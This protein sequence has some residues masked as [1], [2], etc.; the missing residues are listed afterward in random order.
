VPHSFCR[1]SD[2]NHSYL[3]DR[4]PLEA[5]ARSAL[6]R[7]LAD[8]LFRDYAPSTANL[9]ASALFR[10]LKL[11][12]GETDV[13][14]PWRALYDLFASVSFL[15]T[16][17]NDIVG[18]DTD[19]LAATLRR[20]IPR[21]RRYFA[22]GCVPEMLE[23][24]SAGLVY[25]NHNEAERCL[26][27]LSLFLPHHKEQFRAWL[28]PLLPVWS[29]IVDH[30]TWDNKFLTLIARA[31]RASCKTDYTWDALVE[32]MFSRVLVRLDI[33]LG[34]SSKLVEG[35]AQRQEA[36]AYGEIGEKGGVATSF[37]KWA[38][39]ALTPR[40][41]DPVFAAIER[42]LRT[43]ETYYHPSNTGKW[44][45]SLGAILSVMASTL[46]TRHRK[47]L[48][49]NSS[50]HASK[51]LR[52]EDR[53]RVV[54]VLLRVANYAL[55]SKDDDMSLQAR[56]AIRSLGYLSPQTVFDPLMERLYF[57]L[58]TVT[59]TH[60]TSLA[61]STL[62]V[63]AHPLFSRTI[64]PAGARHLVPFL[65]LALPGIDSND[66]AKTAE[67]FKFFTSALQWVPLIDE[68]DSDYETTN[69]NDAAAKMATSNFGDWCVQLWNQLTVY[70]SNLQ[71]QEKLSY[72]AIWEHE[73][74]LGPFLRVFF[75]QMSPAFRLSFVRNQIAEYVTR[76]RHNNAEN[77]VLL[78]ITWA[79][80]SDPATVL[81]E[82]IPR[83]LPLVWKKDKFFDSGV[84]SVS[85]ALKLLSGCARRAGEALVPFVDQLTSTALAAIQYNR[86]PVDNNQVRKLGHELLG[87]ML[88]GLVSY[89]VQDTFYPKDKTNHFLLWG[90]LV[91]QADL[92]QSHWVEPTAAAKDAAQRSIQRVLAFAEEQIRDP[93][94]ADAQVHQACLALVAVLRAGNAF[95]FA[96]EEVDLKVERE[97]ADR[98][99]GRASYL[100]VPRHLGTEVPQLAFVRPALRDLIFRLHDALKTKRA[101]SSDPF[102]DL[103]SVMDSYQMGDNNDAAGMVQLQARRQW[104]A[105]LLNPLD[106]KRQSRFLKLWKS[107]AFYLNLLPLRGL[108]APDTAQGR[109]M[110]GQL[111]DL[112]VSSYA[113]VRVAAQETLLLASMT[114][115]GPTR[116]VIIPRMVD[117]LSQTESEDVA[118]G[119][120]HFF[121]D[122]IT[123]EKARM[124]RKR[125]LLL[126]LCKCSRFDNAKIQVL[127]SS[128]FSQFR[129]I[130]SGPER[131]LTSVKNEFTER[132]NRQILERNAAIVED[133]LTLAATGPHWRYELMICVA[134]IATM[135]RDSPSP[136]A[137]R[138]L[139]DRLV[140][141]VQQI[142]KVAITGVTLILK[143][144]GPT[145]PRV[146]EWQDGMRE[147]EMYD[148][149]WEGF[150]SHRFWHKH[151]TAAFPTGGTPDIVAI[152]HEAFARPGFAEKICT[153]LAIDY[154]SPAN[155]GGGFSGAHRGMSQM[156]RKYGLDH[157]FGSGAGG[158][159]GG[160]GRGGGGESSISIDNFSKAWPLTPGTCA[161][162]SFHTSMAFFWKAVAKSYGTAP[163]PEVFFAVAEAFVQPSRRRED[164]AVGA[165][166]IA[167]IIRGKKAAPERLL[168]FLGPALVNANNDA[169]Y[170]LVAMMRFAVYNRD[171][172]RLTPLVR[173]IFDLPAETANASSSLAKALRYVDAQVVEF[174]WRLE[175]EYP[176][177][178][179]QLVSLVSYD[180]GQVRLTVAGV[181]FHLASLAKSTLDF[182]PVLQ[183]VQPA[184]DD[185]ATLSRKR[186]TGLVFLAHAVRSQR[187]RNPRFYRTLLQFVFA[188]HSD[189]DK[190]VSMLAKNLTST[191]ALT[192]FS[193][194][195]LDEVQD[196]L[197]ELMTDMG[198]K[199]RAA[200]PLV[201]TLF[202]FNHRFVKR[203]KSFEFLVDQLLLDKHVE[204]RQ[205]AELALR[206]ML[207]GQADEQA[208]LA[209][210]AKCTTWRENNFV[211]SAV[212]AYSAIVLSFPY[213][214]PAFVE[215]ILAK[216]VRFASAP[217]PIG[218]T[219]KQT[220][221]EFWRT[222]RDVAE[223]EDA[224]LQDAE[225]LRTVRGLG[226][227]SNYFA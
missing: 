53:E 193:G 157:M 85:W 54:K 219:V 7:Q 156:L 111:V 29:L 191:Q 63:V 99:R 32:P 182:E 61:L 89:R 211:H 115:F 144:H 78:I 168:T 103:I 96:V 169:H 216:L 114:F 165:E 136:R 186:E 88:A 39:W 162:G 187:F 185:A 87:T 69:E 171:P 125:E 117:L 116:D 64:Y 28:P 192:T 14:L 200:M 120:L 128:V 15:K 221:A 56:N 48:K 93:V 17:P 160:G 181:L 166:L 172:R 106:P 104:G 47:Q 107:E 155:S 123:L 19:R 176:R 207:T 25:P 205:V 51:I 83:I 60:Q 77:E 151:Y 3:Q 109:L 18:S 179:A 217:P 149:P 197:A 158:G 138:F 105:K 97:V 227:Q 50:T 178:L 102:V 31:A 163:V 225:L 143:Q 130:I 52:T 145:I 173:L 80:S 12:K 1:G 135:R 43:C 34:G 13:V 44:T 35:F 91:S 95:P 188:A 198:W 201:I 184:T 21:A 8:L 38:I 65:Q 26:G 94:L 202:D 195:G 46:A 62:G 226:Y 140:S 24:F 70:L 9:T 81:P 10:L 147:G 79:V 206:S 139:T 126:A 68:S 76:E 215:P 113:A 36:H 177:L 119:C 72:R 154:A 75:A 199:V 129:G 4:N 203:A 20:F 42:F 37:A 40:D 86:S 67:T 180:Y 208:V 124:H 110:L 33:T 82:L 223:S 161:M 224:I 5:A 57:A 27:C 59:A 71:K 98:D 108:D 84:E 122:H 101:D 174:D 45:A 22:P 210:D 118:R 90:Q 74:V 146:H 213:T 41:D 133:M 142:R 6:I 23:L 196:E 170:D 175:A 209:V 121:N 2:G 152:V 11:D 137:V 222:H 112:S 132:K 167:G 127:V 30:A 159:G 49:E 148:R 58:Q 153:F 204:V 141:D 220:V 100:R 183:S 150:L 66:N 189:V 55:W 212:L 131:L 194:P 16:F 164:N 73:T 134:L 214:V 92:G 190:D 218:P